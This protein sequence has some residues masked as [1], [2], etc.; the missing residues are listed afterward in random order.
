MNLRKKIYTRVRGCGGKY[1]E[2][3]VDNNRD[4]NN[5]DIE[6]VVGLW[7][8][9]SQTNDDKLQRDFNENHDNDDRDKDEVKMIMTRMKKRA[10]RENRFKSVILLIKIDDFKLFFLNLANS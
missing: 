8:I 6:F 3:K 5:D 4:Y 1:L 2:N 7:K 9:L 10:Q